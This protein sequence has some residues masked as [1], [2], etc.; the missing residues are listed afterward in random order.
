ME[1]TVA[2]HA[3]IARRLVRLFEQRFDPGRAGSASLDTIGEVQAIDH[4][5]DMVESLDED[6]ILR[7]FL[8]LILKTL[9]TN[10]YQNLP[11]GAPKPALAVKLASSTIDLL[12]LPRPLYAL[13]VY[14]PRTKGVHM[15]AGKDGR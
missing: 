2:R 5:L 8:T 1:A 9:R 4:A 10:Y 12:P 3:P 6:R 7:G 15:L 13:Y 11:G 14:S